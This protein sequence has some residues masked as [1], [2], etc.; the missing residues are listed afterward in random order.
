MQ[1][2]LLQ[3][4]PEVRG[5]MR[6]HKIKRA[7]A[8]GSVCTDSFSDESDIDFIVRLEEGLD[9]VEY[10][11]HYFDALM[12]L[13]LFWSEVLIL[14]LRKRWKTHISL[15][16]STKPK[17]SFMNDE[18]R[19]NLQDILD[20]IGGIEQYLLAKPGFAEFES[21]RMMRKAIERELEIIGEATNR[22]IKPIL[23]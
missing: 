17:R 3:K 22:I 16:L 10:T 11:R 20:S 15:R 21:N 18:V 1:G 23:K 9:P 19:K 14:L 12:N 4:L 13:N 5:I 2:I 6:Q 7:Y 8:F